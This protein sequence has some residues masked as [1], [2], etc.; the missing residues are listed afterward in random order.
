MSA[1]EKGNT[2]FRIEFFLKKRVDLINLLSSSFFALNLVYVYFERRLG[3]RLIEINIHN[4][5]RS[6]SLFTQTVFTTTRNGAQSQ[7]IS[8]RLQNRC[9]DCF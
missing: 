7:S 2:F 6:I 5:H 9:P 3:S 1:E 4:L 8:R